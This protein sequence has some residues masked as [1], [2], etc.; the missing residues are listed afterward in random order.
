MA[1]TP[2]ELWQMRRASAQQN[3]QPDEAALMLQQLLTPGETA[4][5]NVPDLPFL[6]LPG[7]H[8]EHTQP[9]LPVDG[10]TQECAANATKPMNAVV[11][12]GAA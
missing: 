2:S 10:D 8:L 9:M 11:D 7:Q 5:N 6:Y 12:G 3:T 1:K 4:P